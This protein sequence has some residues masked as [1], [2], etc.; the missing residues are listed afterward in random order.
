MKLSKTDL[1]LCKTCNTMK[2]ISSG[3]TCDRCEKCGC[4]YFSPDWNTNEVSREDL[5]NEISKILVKWDMPTRQVVINE[6]LELL[7][8][9][10]IK[11]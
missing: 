10:Y 9:K 3:D 4:G 5:R 11:K 8:A 6:I 2:H 7:K 1:K